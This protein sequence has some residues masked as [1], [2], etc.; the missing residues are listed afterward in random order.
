M[1]F[2]KDGP[3]IPNELLSA[4]DAGQVLFFCGAG[5]SRAAAGLPDFIDLAYQVLT[6]LGSSMESPARK[7][8]MEAIA[9]RHKGEV[10]SSA[11]MD[12]VFGFLEREFEADDV[13]RAVASV[14]KPP[15][16]HTLIF[17][18]ALLDLSTVRSGDVRIVTTNFDRLFE[19]ACTTDVP[20][21]S[22]PSLPDPGRPLSFRGI[23]HLHGR[24]DD[25]YKGAEHDEF[26]LSTAEFGHSYLADGWATRFIQSLARRFRI[27]FVGYAADDPPVQYLL[28]AINRYGGPGNQIYAFHGG[29]NDDAQAQW[30]HR[31]V[32]PIAYDPSGAHMALWD[33]LCAWAEQA[34]DVGAWRDKV[35][36]RSSVGPA[37][38][39]REERGQVA[40]LVSSF[41]GV[42]HVV[43]ATA[44][45]SAEWLMVFDRNERYAAPE[46]RSHPDGTVVWD[47]PFERYGIDDDLEPDLFDPNKLWVD[48]T[49]PSEAWNA[50]SPS[51]EDVG[52]AHAVGG[53]VAPLGGRLLPGLSDREEALAGWLVKS[54]FHPATVWW[55]TQ[56]SSLHPSLIERLDWHLVHQP[57]H[58]HPALR[59]AWRLLFR[60]WKQPTVP[61]ETRGFAIVH[62]SEK[63]GWG[64]DL[65]EEAMELFRP[66]LTVRRAYAETWP[67]LN[68]ELLLT[69]LV[70][71]DITY[72]ATDAKFEIPDPWLALA[73]PR[74]RQHVEAAL[75]LELSLRE[76]DLH[77]ITDLTA[78][79]G[80]TT[81]GMASL[82]VLLCS[83][84]LRW[85]E[86]DPKSAKREAARWAISSP[87]AFRRLQTWAAQHPALFDGTEVASLV[88]G[89][90]DSLFWDPYQ[91]R[92]LLHVL[93]TRWQEIAEDSQSAILERIL[94]GPIPTLDANPDRD[95]IGARFRLSRWYWL[96]NKTGFAAQ[97]PATVVEDL[98]RLVPDYGEAEAVGALDRRSGG[99]LRLELDTESAWLEAL[100]ISEIAS[101]AER[102]QET[103]FSDLV[104]RRAFLGLVKRRPVTA[105]R[106][107]RWAAKR[108]AAFSGRLWAT[109]LNIDGVSTWAPRRV[110]V[111]ARTLAS[112]TPKDLS[113]IALDAARWLEGYASV[114][115]S[116]DPGGFDVI[117]AALLIATPEAD[118][119][120]WGGGTRRDWVLEAINSP[121]DGL[122]SSLLVPGASVP[123]IRAAGLPVDLKER[124]EALL[125]LPGD[126]RSY[127]I[128]LLGR[129]LS[130]LSFY[131]FDWMCEHLVPRD[132]NGDAAIAFW[133]GAL[134]GQRLPTAEAFTFLKPQMLGLARNERC[135]PDLERILS[136]FLLLGWHGQADGAD[137]HI[138]ISDVELREVLIHGGEQTRAQLLWR[139]RSWVLSNP[140]EWGPEV[141]RFFDQAWPKQ[142]SARTS[143]TSADLI[144][145]AFA[146]PDHFTVIAQRIQPYLVPITRGGYLEEF[147][148]APKA[149]MDAHPV[150]ML[151]LLWAVIPEQTRDWPYGTSEVITRLASLPT[152][153]HAPK[154]TELIRRQHQR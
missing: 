111:V 9:A 69:D 70:V 33:T 118:Q 95:R 40:Y 59:A 75:N 31:G 41:A 140:N 96:A 151:D 134:S 145:L 126:W 46:K 52:Q 127:A 135:P 105:I 8:V 30:G 36:L 136:D 74:L 91:E 124:F 115:R 60:V 26:I 47:D 78:G 106:S 130:W 16:D 28:E 132:F 48:R 93:A 147:A 138:L 73:V 7:L 76:R 149:L 90:D 120:N 122:L 103:D 63:E 98:Q 87:Y 143:A 32:T 62:R 101:A 37:A 131:A 65:V 85:L 17:H 53:L 68:R 67:A 39:S 45:L 14:L 97:A 49:V 129:Q 146:L 112:L 139:L 58:V 113:S 141:V 71:G 24:V 83:Y 44:T 88:A 94:S 13:R 35:L 144:R 12:R 100:P 86:F 38:L 5:V 23:M 25:H 125:A 152:I 81:H 150:T 84:M 153:R 107:L 2:I 57:E 6:L 117:W 89:M 102:D 34:R 54:C 128:C 43:T 18:R 116:H 92:D 11:G 109:L 77:Y 72:P 55:A 133:T 4:R 137:H 29:S 27:V 99:I 56:K 79:A 22:P 142:R 51:L 80:R 121:L 104:Q 15:E 50:F 110:S 154:L 82:L 1:R 108:H 123:S 19:D 3:V 10:S 20:S 114:L 42:Q 61:A 119:N 148:S 64:R 21:H 66:L